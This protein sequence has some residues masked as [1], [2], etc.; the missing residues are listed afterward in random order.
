MKTIAVAAA[1]GGSGKSTIASALSARASKES[2][3]VAMMDLT[4]RTRG[5]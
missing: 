5:T 2:L 3:C 4:T 1:K